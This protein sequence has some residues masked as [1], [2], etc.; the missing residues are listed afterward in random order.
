MT[1]IEIIK[2]R[3]K[4]Y[5]FTRYT[6]S[7]DW[8]AVAPAGVDGFSVWL[9]D[10]KPGYTVGY[11][12][13]HE[14]FDDE[15]AALDAFAF[16]LSEDCRLKVIQRGKFECSWTLEGKDENGQWSEDSKTSLVFIPFWR[17]KCTIYRQN[18]L[19]KTTAK[20]EVGKFEEAV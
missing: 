20:V 3:L 2:H 9:T 10:K 17:K 11:D 13:W 6:S 1:A 4:G 16:G 12:G 8:I 15:G 7:D 19:I 18:R 14:E 5:P